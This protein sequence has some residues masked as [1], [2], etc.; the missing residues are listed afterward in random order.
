MRACC[1]AAACITALTAL[2]FGVLPALRACGG[3]LTGL[4]EGSRGGVGGRKERLRSALV[5]AEIAGSVVLLVSSG[6]LIRALWRLQ[7]VDPGFRAAGVLTLRT[8]LPMPKY[9]KVADRDR[10]YTH[11]LQEARR[12]P[13]VSARRFRQLPSRWP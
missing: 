5:V 8:A 7:N 3:D 4:R 2:G 13:G 12:L 6:L 10:F 11:V 9:D 1:F